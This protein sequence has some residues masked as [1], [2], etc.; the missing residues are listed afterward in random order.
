MPRLGGFKI[1]S[2]KECSPLAPLAGTILKRVVFDSALEMKCPKCKAQYDKKTVCETQ[3]TKTPVCYS[4]KVP[5]KPLKQWVL[6][7]PKCHT[8]Y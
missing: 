5:L 6:K 2:N 1:C 7:C 8:V 3:N 4:C